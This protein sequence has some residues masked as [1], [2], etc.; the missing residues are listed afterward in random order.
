MM[1]LR[2][3]LLCSVCIAATSCDSNSTMRTG[4]YSKLNMTNLVTECRQLAEAGVKQNKQ[5]WQDA[6][7][8]PE[9][10]ASLSPQFVKLMDQGGSTVID[11]QV[12]GGFD[13][14]GLLV[15]CQSPD[16][17]FIPHKGR[18]WRITKLAP[19]VFEYRE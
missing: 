12:S 1:T 14:R 3:W 2:V 15:V 6:D 16:T 4:P 13:H 8:L 9:Q 19:D 18:N 7:V 11:I 17:N 5:K 10:V